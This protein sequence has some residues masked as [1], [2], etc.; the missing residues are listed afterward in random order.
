MA[1]TRGIRRK[2][3]GWRFGL[4]SRHQKMW[5]LA[6]ATTGSPPDECGRSKRNCQ[7]SAGL[8]K[9]VEPLIANAAQNSNPKHRRDGSSDQKPS[10]AMVHGVNVSDS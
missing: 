7:T 2:L 5:T 1:S 10:Q 6:A 3:S 9:N 4:V 8:Q